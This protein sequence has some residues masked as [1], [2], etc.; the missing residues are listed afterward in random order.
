MNQ[1]RFRK[2]TLRREHHFL[3]VG[4]AY[5]LQAVIDDASAIHVTDDTPNGEL[6]YRARF[7]FDPNS[8]DMNNSNSHVI[9]YGYAG[10]STEVIRLEF[11]RSSRTAWPTSPAGPANFQSWTPC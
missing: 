8:I 9:F 7:Y 1:I 2:F 4:S 10:A 3:Q 6:R 5:G 11:R